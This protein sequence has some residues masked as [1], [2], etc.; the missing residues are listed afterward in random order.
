MGREQG[1]GRVEFVVGFCFLL[2]PGENNCLVGL[3]F[4]RQNRRGER[5]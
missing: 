1:D 5:P 4:S 3:K 2:N